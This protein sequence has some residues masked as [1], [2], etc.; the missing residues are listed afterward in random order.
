MQYVVASATVKHIVA[1]AGTIQVVA[2]K[3]VIAEVTMQDII[4]EP[5]N[6]PIVPLIPVQDVIPRFA[7]DP[8]VSF[9]SVDRVVA[10][11][12]IDRIVTI[13]AI[14][15]VVSFLSVND[16]I[17]GR[18]IDRVVSEAAV[19]R[20]WSA[21]RNEKII[22]QAAVD[23][24]RRDDLRRD[25]DAIIAAPCIDEDRGH[26]GEGL[27]DA[28]SGDHDLCL[29]RRQFDQHIVVA[30]GQIPL[31]AQMRMG[32]DVDYQRT[33][34]LHMGQR[35]VARKGIGARNVEVDDHNFAQVDIAIPDRCVDIRSETHPQLPGSIEDPQRTEQRMSPQRHVVQQLAPAHFAIPIGIVQIQIDASEQTAFHTGLGDQ[36]VQF[37]SGCQPAFEDH[38][39]NILAGAIDVLGIADI[40]AVQQIARSTRLRIVTNARRVVAKREIR[41]HSDR[42]T[43]PHS[44]DRPDRNVLAVAEFGFQPRHVEGHQRHV[45]PQQNSNGGRR[46][47][48]NRYVELGFGRR[49]A[50]FGPGHAFQVIS[51]CHVFHRGQ[52]FAEAAKSAEGPACR[53][54]LQHVAAIG[55]HEV[56]QRQP[57]ASIDDGYVQ[58]I[59]NH[60]NR[61]DELAYRPASAAR[62]RHQIGHRQRSSRQIAQNRNRCGEGVQDRAHWIQHVVDRLQHGCDHVAHKRTQIQR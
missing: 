15:D 11:S 53:S 31:F 17:R 61:I 7:K 54:R 18:T 13:Q 38:L 20:R 22:P 50:H 48:E 55:C 49:L 2:P 41:H 28:K 52:I 35:R 9:A 25:L 39:G 27:L 56:A 29:I 3:L 47:R 36:H 30:I 24:D 57:H 1:V 12:T 10:A 58:Q 59:H 14:E 60:R 33:V 62:D 6:D 51:Q 5:A 34:W 21:T 43:E 26:V 32:A 23:Q 16:I 42:T 40:E 8:I 19:D 45:L 37:A 46:I 44:K 4:A